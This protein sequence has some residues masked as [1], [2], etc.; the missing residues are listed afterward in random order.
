MVRGT[1]NGY[2]PYMVGGSVPGFQGYAHQKGHGIGG[3]FRGLMR[4]VIPIAK[5][6]GKAIGRRALKTAANVAGD[7]AHGH[8]LE[9]AIKR[10]AGQTVKRAAKQGRRRLQRGKGLGRR[11]TRNSINIAIVKRKPV[12]KK[13]RKGR[14]K[15]PVDIFA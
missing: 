13:K 5:Q 14:K 6:A 10:R 8:S 4:M 11:G 1:F 12:S 15:A 9:G 2:L 7:V 3:I